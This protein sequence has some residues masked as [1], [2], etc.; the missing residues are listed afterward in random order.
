MLLNA[1]LI[2]DQ[3]FCSQTEINDLQLMQICLLIVGSHANI[4]CFKII[5]NVTNWMDLL[6]ERNELNTYLVHSLE[7]KYL[8]VYHLECFKCQTHSLHHNI[9]LTTW[10]A[11]FVQFGKMFIIHLIQLSKHITLN[12]MK[13]FTI[14]FSKFEYNCFSFRIKPRIY[15]SKW[16]C[17]HS[18]FDRVFSINYEGSFILY[19]E[20]EFHFH[21]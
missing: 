18:F 2:C 12:F 1:V 5:I 3:I 8:S 15:C 9:F 11:I 14:L 17:C 19:A 4:V 13:F 10:A 21:F 20:I 16:T 6:E 7:R